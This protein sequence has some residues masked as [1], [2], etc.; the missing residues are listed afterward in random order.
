VLS[1]RDLLSNPKPLEARLLMLAECSTAVASGRGGRNRQLAGGTGCAGAHSG[2][3][4]SGR[5]EPIDRA[6]D[7]RFANRRARAGD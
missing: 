1:I 2:W 7:A 6:A 5:L 3:R 4:H